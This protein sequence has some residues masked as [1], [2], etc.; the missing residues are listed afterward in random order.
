MSDVKLASLAGAVFILYAATP[1]ARSGAQPANPNVARQATVTAHS[2]NVV[3]RKYF[4]RC[5]AD[6]LIPVEGR[7]FAD[8]GLVQGVWSIGSA[9]GANRAG[10]L[11]FTWKKP[12]RIREVVFFQKTVWSLDDCWRDY[13]VSLGGSA[14][15]VTR[16]TLLKR[17]GPQSILLD[18]P[19][20]ASELTLTFT[21]SYGGMPGASE[22]LIF[23]R[24]AMTGDILLAMGG[25][26]LARDPYLYL[27]LRFFG[28][29]EPTAERITALIAEMKKRHG[30]RFNAARSETRL[31]ALTNDDPADD[32]DPLWGYRMSPLEQLRFQIL[33]FD[34]EAG[35]AVIPAFPGAEGFG[36]YATGGRGGRVIEVTNLNGS[37]PGSFRAAV[38]ATGSR[39]VV[40][41][42]A[43]TI[44]H[45][46]RF[47]ITNP[48]L[49]IAGQ[50]A[51]GDGICIQGH[52]VSVYADNVIIRFLRVRPGD[53]L[54]RPI[55]DAISGRFIQDVILDH[56]SMSWS[57]DEVCTWYALGNV[58]VQWCLMSES[59]DRSL[60]PKG[61]HG[62]GH[63][64]GGFN[65]SSHHNLI[66]HN[67]FR[68]PRFGGCGN[69]KESLVDFRNNVV[70]N[71]VTPGY[72]GEGGTYNFVHNYYKRG[73]SSRSRHFLTPYR[74]KVIG[75][76][77]WHLTGNLMVGDEAM[78]RDNW[79]GVDRR[80]PRSDQPFPIAHV[81]THSAEEAYRLVL[82]HVGAIYPKRGAVDARVI[83][84]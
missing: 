29:P 66:A 20:E 81:T 25:W 46:D 18:K 79:R 56:C 40:F 67:S 1:Q 59:L 7:G 27:H 16:G 26:K 70:Y 22:V 44:R 76:G 51:P 32:A 64:M 77:T 53:V 35:N 4:A 78:T 15:P 60:H 58:T 72:G 55:G 37:G 68:N 71:F 45:E 75:Y 80:V 69:L 42:V 12:V 19:H 11:K 36:M 82:D 21:S 54:G 74:H 17:S 43:G 49:T 41:R 3:R 47:V 28:L 23:P 13:E 14:T 63:A 5:A 24:K 10:W 31:A 62:A 84:D 39:T 6:G 33:L 30:D 48:D 2:E 34:G 61:G 50:T 38:E 73:P 57:M 8:Y 65:L 52:E 83:N 9:E